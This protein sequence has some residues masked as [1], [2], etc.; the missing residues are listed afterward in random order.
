MIKKEPV[1]NPN[2]VNFFKQTTEFKGELTT[3]NDI[4]LDGKLE[5]KL[6]SKSKLVLGETGEIKGEVYCKSA[7]ISGKIIGKIF[8]EDIITLN[9][10]S[11]IQGDISTNKIA[12]EPGAV[13]NGICKM[14]EDINKENTEIV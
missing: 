3:E 10:T 4:K 8:V 9:S 7:Y 6:V 14:G 13:F 2:D 5:G 1:S 11:K 12:I